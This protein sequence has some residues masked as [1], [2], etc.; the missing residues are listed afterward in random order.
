MSSTV[1]IRQTNFRKKRLLIYNLFLIFLQRKFQ[2]DDA[3]AGVVEMPFIKGFVYLLFIN[4]LFHHLFPVN[5]AVKK[6]KLLSHLKPESASL[7]AKQG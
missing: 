3:F 4:T 1:Q 2:D 7:N 6:L 5:L